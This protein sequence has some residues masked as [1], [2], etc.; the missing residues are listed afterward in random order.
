MV[1]TMYIPCIFQLY[2]SG[3]HIIGIMIHGIFQVYTMIIYQL[4]GFQMSLCHWQAEHAAIFLNHLAAVVGQ[5][6]SQ[7]YLARGQQRPCRLA[8][9]H[10]GKVQS[11]LYILQVG[12]LWSQ[13]LQ[14]LDHQGPSWPSQLAVMVLARAE[15]P[16][17]LQ[18][19]WR[20]RLYSNIKDIYCLSQSPQGLAL[21][22]RSFKW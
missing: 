1:Y 15:S 4:S 9:L 6:L 5:Y 3:L 7:R 8:G 14:G 12:P 20:G 13:V 19:Q 18:L 16:G 2:W 11:C 17:R 10:L 21:G 22:S